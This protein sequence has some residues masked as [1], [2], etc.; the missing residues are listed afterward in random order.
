[1]DDEGYRSEFDSHLCK[2]TRGFDM[3]VVGQK[4]TLYTVRLNIAKRSK[5][6]WMQIKAVDSTSRSKIEGTSN[7]DNPDVS[8]NS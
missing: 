4:S 3:V 1:M 6:Q 2:L 8:I 7:R 5:G